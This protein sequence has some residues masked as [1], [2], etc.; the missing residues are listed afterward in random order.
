VLSALFTSLLASQP[1]LPL[2]GVSA[3]LT[4]R[5][6]GSWQ[7]Q[8]DV[9]VPA[10]AGLRPA[11]IYFHGG[12]WHGGN[13]K[14]VAE[15]L[16]PYLARGFVAVAVSYRGSRIAEAP[17]AVT[18]A[19]CA[20]HWLVNNAS[21]YGIDRK[22]VVLTGHSA[23]GH[24]ALITGYLRPEAGLDGE[25]RSD[26]SIKPAAVVA[27]NA[28]SD[29]RDY[30]LQRLA[31]RDPIKWLRPAEKVPALATAVSPS[32]HVRSGLP[33]TISVHAISDPEIPHAQ[34]AKLHDQLRTANV[35]NEL[36]TIQSDGHLTRQ[37]PA[38]EVAR[39]YDRVFAF[40]SRSGVLARRASITR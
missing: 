15:H 6:V 33:P 3:D 13:R 40:L 5:R 16:G 24:L 36:V 7:G 22:R 8:L 26:P 23:G 9:Y 10:A 27:W 31:D 25:C 39:A 35:H 19:R 14:S 21:S 29:L 28:P 4:Y 30:M 34:A 18:D 32:S 1:A 20:F 17:A 38:S 2:G 11:L 12:E 37:H